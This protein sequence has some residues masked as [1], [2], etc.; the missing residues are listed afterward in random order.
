MK[1]N[2]SINGEAFNFGPDTNADHSVS[3]LVTEISK[4]W[5]NAEWLDNS[6]KL[7][8]HE[9]SLLKLNCDKAM[10]LLNW[11]SKLSFED[12]ARYTANWYKSYYNNSKNIYDLT[13]NQIKDYNEINSEI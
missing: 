4:I 3:D 5:G 9:S 12:T 13:V 1:E 6:G 11:K 2:I 7:N 8:V 10:S